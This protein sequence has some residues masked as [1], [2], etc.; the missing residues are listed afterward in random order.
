MQQASWLL[1][2]LVNMQAIGLKAGQS[3]AQSR[4]AITVDARCT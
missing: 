1:E 2:Q 3:A 4:L